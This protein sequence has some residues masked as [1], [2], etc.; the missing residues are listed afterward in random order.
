EIRMSPQLHYLL[1][2]YYPTAFI[3]AIRDGG[4]RPMVFMGHGLT[5]AFFMMTATVAAAAL[6][7]V[8]V[9]VR[10]MPPAGVTA[11]LSVVLI[12]CRSL[13]ALIYG[14][15]LVPLVSLAK[16][17][18]QIRV[19]LVMATFSLLYPM[20]RMVDLVPTKTLVESASVISSDRADSLRTRFDNE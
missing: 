12:L 1:Y 16:P 2:G 20:L 13:G 8:G 3:Q 15:V 4:F 18:T 19:A 7:R 11:Y 5:A 6:W 14:A 10:R 17:R 9:S